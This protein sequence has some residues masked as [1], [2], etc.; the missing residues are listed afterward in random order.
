MRFRVGFGSALRIWIGVRVWAGV[1]F[2]FGVRV[3]IGFGNWVKCE[4]TDWSVKSQYFSKVF[5]KQ[6]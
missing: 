4:T 2:R 3:G 6:F 5:L 1:R